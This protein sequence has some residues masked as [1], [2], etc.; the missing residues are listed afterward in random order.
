MSA[1]SY[2]YAEYDGYHIIIELDKPRADQV[3]KKMFSRMALFLKHKIIYVVIC[4]PG[5]ERMNPKE[6]KKYFVYGRKILKE[7]NE[8]SEFFGYMIDKDLK[9][10]IFKD[11]QLMSKEK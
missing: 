3:A 2:E 8:N 11:G 10:E 4:Y 1:T 7:L 6:C 5:T 9:S